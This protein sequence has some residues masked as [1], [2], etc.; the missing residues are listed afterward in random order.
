M[1]SAKRWFHSRRMRFCILVSIFLNTNDIQTRL[2]KAR[3]I[4]FFT[5]YCT[6]ATVQWKKKLKCSAYLNTFSKCSSVENI[7]IGDD[8]AHRL[9]IE[10]NFRPPVSISLYFYHTNACNTSYIPSCSLLDLFDTNEW[11]GKA[12]VCSRDVKVVHSCYSGHKDLHW[13]RYENTRRKE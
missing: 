3:K 11:T 9:S 4:V 6:H 1:R 5:L 2:A 10:L 12:Y 7:I 13:C 8:F